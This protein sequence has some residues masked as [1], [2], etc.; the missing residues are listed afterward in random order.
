M[1]GKP[2]AAPK[3]VARTTIAV[4]GARVHNL[5]NVSLE[6]PRD[7]LIVVTGLSGSGKS[8]LAFDTIY[9]EG[10]RR[11][12]ESLST[13]AR[14]FVAQLPKPDVDFMHGLSPVISIEQRTVGR[15]PRSTVGTLTD[16]ASYLNLL[17]ATVGVAHCPYSGIELP[18]RTRGQ[19][20]DLCMK[21][22]RGTEIELTAPV[23]PP[24]GEELSV[25]FTAVRKQGYRQLY[26]DD[27]LVDLQDDLAVDET[28][29]HRF[30]VVIARLRI[31]PAVERQ[32]ATAVENALLVGDHLIG[33]TP[34]GAGAA[35]RRAFW[36]EL[37]NPRHGVVFADL[38]G[39]FF[40]FNDPNS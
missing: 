5:K 40:M 20:L 37:G 2:K 30:R 9:A 35:Q 13:F 15:N 1:S 25:L 10:Q 32:L 26:L 36:Q 4:Q 33:I 38:A 23:W 18:R 19:V 34:L 16:V 14:R 27:A 21:L 11:F 6:L 8:S 22:P 29:E 17:F 39:D 3:P 7:S 12:M 31:E 28:R 24:F